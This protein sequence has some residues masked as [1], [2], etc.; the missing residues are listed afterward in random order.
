MPNI[1][2]KLGEIQLSLNAPKDETNSF[3]GYKYRNAEGI[4]AAFKALG[5]EKSSLTMS[6]KVVLVG[7]K[8]FL[9]ATA[10][11]T[12]EGD[13]INVDGWAMHA[14]QKKGMDDAQITG[15]ASSYAR[16]YALCGL[17]A[18]DDSSV[19][20]DTKDNRNQGNQQNQNQGNAISPVEALARKMLDAINSAEDIDAINMI[21]RN[22]NFQMDLERVAKMNERTGAHIKFKLDEAIKRLQYEGD[23]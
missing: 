2:E 4:I 5:I 14:T 9:V 16:K 11:L 8:L 19:D 23:Q 6:D 20:P 21:S 7:D 15:S 3:G 13:S 22:E 10:T 18:I 17:F 1:S 12:I